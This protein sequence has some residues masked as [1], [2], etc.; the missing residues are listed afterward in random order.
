MSHELLR[1]LHSV[2][3]GWQVL[4]RPVSSLADDVAQ[5]FRI[6]E[7]LFSR[8]SLVRVLAYFVSCGF[9]DSLIFRAT[10]GLFWSASFIWGGEAATGTVWDDRKRFPRHG[11]PVSRPPSRKALPRLPDLWA[12]QP[13]SLGG[14]GNLRPTGRR[15]YLAGPNATAGPLS[16]GPAISQA[17]Q[18]RGAHTLASDC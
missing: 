6:L 4:E 1:R 8:W 12:H 11:C 13:V 2:T 9:N 14:E 18:G 5:P 16:R 15:R 10:A 7:A 17:H 3:V